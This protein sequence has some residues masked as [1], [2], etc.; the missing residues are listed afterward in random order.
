MLD[1]GNTDSVDCINMIGKC[2]VVSVVIAGQ[3]AK[4]LVDTE[5]TISMF[6]ESFY[7]RFLPDYTRLRTDVTLKLR[8]A[9]GLSI[10]YIG[11]VKVD[12]K[13]MGQN[14]KSC[15]VLIV[16]ESTDPVTKR[17]K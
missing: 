6:T 12:M 3:E 17:R 10:P 15:G 14:L 4:C 13:V 9:N 8:A 1:G 7:N 2:P 5:S 11:Y 16:K